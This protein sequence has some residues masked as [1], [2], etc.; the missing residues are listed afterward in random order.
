MKTNK[1]KMTLLAGFMMLLAACN[2]DNVAPNN[3]N[4]PSKAKGNLSMNITDAPIDNTNISGAFVTIT[5]IKVDGQVYDGFKGPKTINLLELQNGNSLNIGSQPV[6]TGKYSTITLVLNTETDATGGAP[7]CYLQMVNGT[8]EKLEISGNGATEI[9]LKPKEM[10]VTEN[11]NTEIIM[12][13]DLR[14]AVKS[15]QNDYSFVTLGSLKS[16]VRVENKTQTGTIKGKIDNYSQLNGNA[17]VYLYKKGEFS[18]SEASN[19]ETGYANATTSAKVDAAG[20]FTLAFL[21]DGEYEIVCEKTNN[22]SAGLLLELNS[23]SNL[24][25][26]PVKAGSQTS[27]SMNLKLGVL[28]L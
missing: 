8:K 15:K 4:D 7:G 1:V 18:A 26:V 10:V 27:L 24:K 19:G 11:Q 28:G 5:S 12:D 6:S 13:F 20:N 25:A 9:D 23:S 14:K 17:V 2:K 16:A 3:M 21:P 22:T